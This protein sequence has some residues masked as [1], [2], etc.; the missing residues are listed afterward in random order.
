MTMSEP[1]VSGTPDDG[2]PDEDLS[3]DERERITAILAEI[4]DDDRRRLEPPPSIWNAI[5]DTVSADRNGRPDRTLTLTDDGN[6]SVVADIS[7]IEQQASTTITLAAGRRATDR[8]SLPP[9]MSA[10]RR[11][12]LPVAA[13]V[14][15]AVVGGLVTWAFS[16]ELAGSDDEATAGVVEPDGDVVAVVSITGDGREETL[17]DIGDSGEARLVTVDGRYHLDIDLD[18]GDPASIDG[19]L[20][21]W[22][23]NTEIDG[24]VS[25]GVVTGDG[26]YALPP[27]LD[28]AD[29][30]IVDV[31]V[32]PIDG[33]PAHSGRSVLRGVFDL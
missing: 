10:W 22:I 29:F 17:N 7:P 27:N 1:P 23:V 15:V 5:V 16:D 30:P 25:L 31:S 24:M 18:V 2:Q 13:A 4:T 21:L 20:E 26:R 14:A 28:P 11:Q 12:W 3:S 9:E 8:P 32:E 6:G 19:Y 33:D